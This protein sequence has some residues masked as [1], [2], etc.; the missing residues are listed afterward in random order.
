MKGLNS[1]TVPFRARVLLPITL[2]PFFLLRLSLYLYLSIYTSR[3]PLVWVFISS[4][5]QNGF[6]WRVDVS[7]LVLEEHRDDSLSLSLLLFT[8]ANLFL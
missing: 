6:L 7:C 3:R 1:V 8:T 5:Y 4:C 2:L